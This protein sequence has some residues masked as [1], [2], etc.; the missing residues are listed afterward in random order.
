MR[1]IFTLLFALTFI[2]NFTFAQCGTVDV[3]TTLATQTAVDNFAINNAGCTE[4]LGSLVIGTTGSANANSLTIVNLTGLAS[5]TKINGNLTVR[6][7]SLTNLAGLSQVTYIGGA[8]GIN[9]NPSL[10]TALLPNLTTLGFDLRFNTNAVL[11]SISMNALPA[12]G[13]LLPSGSL[14]GSINIQNNP[15]LIS[16]SFN[17]LT[18]VG[19]TIALPIAAKTDQ[20][21]I[22]SN[23]KLTN[24]SGFNTVQTINGTFRAFG[25][26][27]LTS[28]MSSGSLTSISGNMTIQTNISLN[29][30]TGIG[31]VSEPS[32]LALTITGN[33]VLSFCQVPSICS[34]LATVKTATVN[35]NASTCATTT[36]IIAAC[37]LP[38]KLTYFSVKD[39]FNGN[40]IKW[41]TASE[42]NNDYFDL[43]RSKDGNSFEKIFQKKGA[44]NSK[45]ELKYEFTD[46][47][48]GA[49]VSYYRLKQ[50][51][52]DGT[53]TY[54]E[55]IAVESSLKAQFVVYPNPSTSGSFSIDTVNT[56]QAYMITNAAGVV[57]S[58]GDIIP[59]KIDLSGQ[60][61]G[62]YFLKAGK[63]TTR[64]IFQ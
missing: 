3:V 40:L 42:L 18:K 12:T 6:G 35:N 21:N 37:A 44:G 56:K 8:L 23:A 2:A 38:I 45:S 13:M 32:I 52:F 26:P 31:N 61:K 49:G 5:I 22:E 50:V 41:T 7:T 59:D 19:Q 4:F 28:L 9:F 46:S 25:N 62:I 11:T 17:S 29:S 48:A 60:A 51:D 53:A 55:I 64:L 30:I 34:Y 57:I 47:K 58:K 36:T 16:L 27:L 15:E 1:R 24:L 54:S 20:L 10:A 14:N 39:V 43:E 33:T 63:N